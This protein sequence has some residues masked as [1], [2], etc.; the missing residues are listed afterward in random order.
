M[1]QFPT[2]DVYTGQ[3]QHSQADEGIMQLLVGKGL[4]KVTIVFHPTDDQTSGDPS[5]ATM[6]L[7]TVTPLRCAATTVE[8]DVAINLTPLVE[9]QPGQ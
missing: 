7:G 6:T 8:R 2:D 5:M 9:A 1:Q 3:Q 4:L